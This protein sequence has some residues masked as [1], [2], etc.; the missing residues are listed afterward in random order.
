MLLIPP[1]GSRSRC[2]LTCSY[3]AAIFALLL[4]CIGMF[5]QAVVTLGNLITDRPNAGFEDHPLP[6]R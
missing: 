5:T 1:S 6:C 3:I 2:G 4:A